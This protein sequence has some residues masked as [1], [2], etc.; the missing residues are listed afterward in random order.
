MTVLKPGPL[1]LQRAGNMSPTTE[2]YVAEETFETRK[3]I[4]TLSLTKPRQNMVATLKSYKLLTYILVHYTANSFCKTVL[5]T[6]THYVAVKFH[7]TKLL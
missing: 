3:R 4:L 5:K 2:C 1:N 7:N 6:A